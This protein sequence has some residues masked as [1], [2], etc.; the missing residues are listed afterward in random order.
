MRRAR[1]DQYRIADGNLEDVVTQGHTALTRRDVVDL[2]ASPVAMQL[3]RLARRDDGLGEALAGVAV[4]VRVHELANDRPVLGDESGH[5]TVACF[6]PVVS[7]SNGR[8]CFTV[9]I[10]IDAAR[11]HNMPRW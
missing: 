5:I 3:R 9:H 7:I 4:N 1:W 6:Q 10:H 2:F 11:W 8:V